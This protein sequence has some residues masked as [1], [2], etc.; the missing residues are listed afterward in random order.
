M[1]PERVLDYEIVEKL[2]EGGIGVVY[3][4]RD[5]RLG[6]SVALKFLREYYSQDAAAME[7]FTREARAASALSHPNICTVHEIEKDAAGRPF[8]VMEL[9][10]GRTLQQRLREG[11]LPLAEAVDVARQL[12]EVL[13]SMHALGIVHRDL[14]PANVFLTESG[15]VKVLDFGL[16]KFWIGD[17]YAEAQAVTGPGAV[18]GTLAY[19]SPEQAWGE[20]VDGR[21]DIFSFGALLYEMATGRQAFA[22]PSAALVFDA[23]QHKTPE[24]PSRLLPQLPRQLDALV[25]LALEKDREKR[26][27]AAALRHELAQLLVPG[28]ASTAALDTPAGTRRASA[29]RRVV[30]LGLGAALVLGAAQLFLRGRSAPGYDAVAVLPFAVTGDAGSEYLGDGIAEGVINGLA[31]LPRLRVV[32][33]SVS[34]KK[35]GSESD[36]NTLAR[37]LRV[38][39]IVTGRVTAQADTLAVSVE[40]VDPERGSQIWGRRFERP[41]RDIL[42]LQEDVGRALQ[43]QLRPRLPA[44]EKDGASRRVT[45]NDEAYRLYLQGR[46]HWERRTDE[47]IRRSLELYKRALGQDPGFALA[48][49]G[50]ADSWVALS[51]TPPRESRPQAKSAALQALQLD[52]SLAEAHTALAMIKFVF[53][54]DFAGA[55]TSFKRA[56]QLDPTH[57]TAHHWYGLLLMSLGRFGDARG[58]LGSAQEQDPLSL[59]IPTNLARVELFARNDA[60]AIAR[61]RR[62]LAVDPGFHWA[63]GFLSV[64]LCRTGSMA[65]AAAEAEQAS[66]KDDA[67]DGAVWKGYA[68]ARAGRRADALRVAREMES[69]AARAYVPPFRVGVVHAALGDRDRALAWFEKAFA[70]RSPWLAYAKY[71]PMLDDA[72]RADRRFQDLMRRVGVE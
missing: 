21:S 62:V 49:A 26:P 15:R 18:L 13:Q 64:A 5:L 51:T 7:R 10:Q 61:L 41:Q 67:A 68:Y 71:D 36:L 11:P 56:L 35:R 60:L 20:D 17:E 44:E 38:G 50:L 2:G 57:A 12:L 32:P 47:A 19:M 4:A 43:E 52:D 25:A 9:L 6:R 46:Y 72:L 59:I 63:H 3:K 29:R 53:D 14:K 34:F 40:L 37:E 8:I 58:E 31:R 30:A 23:V 16:A 28:L 24:P 1:T 33:R 27:S 70:D 65:D 66:A 42:A 55:E 69:R 45:E 48:Y 54:W 22:A 39:A